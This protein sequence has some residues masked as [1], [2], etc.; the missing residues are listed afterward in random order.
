M[1]K[2]EALATLYQEYEALDTVLSAATAAVSH[3]E[4][5]SE[6]LI[7]SHG[8]LGEIDALMDALAS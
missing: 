3:L 6:D 7:K 5:L 2:D 4:P 8:V 1:V